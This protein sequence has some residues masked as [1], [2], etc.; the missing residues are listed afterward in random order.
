MTQTNVAHFSVHCR[1]CD[2]TVSVASDRTKFCPHCGRRL[3]R[4]PWRGV[5]VTALLAG[6]VVASVSFLVPTSVRTVVPVAAPMTGPVAEMLTAAQAERNVELDD[7]HNRLAVVRSARKELAAQA[8]D[9][10]NVAAR[11]RTAVAKANDE[12]R[13]PV[14]VAGRTMERADA[15]ALVARVIGV[16]ATEHLAIDRD[17]E[18]LGR[19]T[20]AEAALHGELADIDRLRQQEPSAEVQRQAEGY[21]DRSPQLP[22]AA[23]LV[24]DPTR[25]VDVAALLK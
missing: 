8:D 14:K 24:P 20:A 4:T 10:A 7:L 1:G 6:G 3:R 25:P 15:D 5:L 21:R 19:I 11:I 22:G 13:W 2:R 18:V 17:A 9:L 16:L 12:D 23:D